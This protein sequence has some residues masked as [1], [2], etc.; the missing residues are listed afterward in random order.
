MLVGKFVVAYVPTFQEKEYY[1]ACA[2]EE[3]YAPPSAYF[4]L[5]GFSVEA[6]FLRGPTR[7]SLLTPCSIAGSQSTLADS[8]A[9]NPSSRAQNRN[10]CTGKEKDAMPFF[11]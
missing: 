3:I 2:C 1:L 8:R 5:F 4:T 11:Y 9:I 10:S 7:N 6:S